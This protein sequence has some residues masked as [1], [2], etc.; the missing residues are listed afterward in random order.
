VTPETDLPFTQTPTPNISEQL[1]HATRSWRERLQPPAQ[2]ARPGSRRRTD[3][4]TQEQFASMIG[5]TVGWYRNL[6][7][8]E[9]AGYSDE[10]LEAVAAGYRLNSD[11]KR[12]LFLLSTGREPIAPHDASSVT[13][14]D[15]L[16]QFLDAQPWPA[17][18]YTDAWEIISTNE[19]MRTW[20]KWAV[21]GAN[22]MKWIFTSSDARTHLHRWSEDW[23]PLMISK[24]RLAL[25]RSP[26]NTAVA[27]LI[28]EIVRANRDAR[29]LWRV[30]ESQA[31]VDAPSRSL[32]LPYHGRIQPVS[33]LP[34]ELLDPPH[35]R[36]AAIIPRPPAA[37]DAVDC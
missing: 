31:T 21:P 7:L 14:I 15:A 37:R 32:N 34:F 6:E 5:Y 25:A 27:D 20:F 13:A 17:F 16:Q 8:G 19:D 22:V 2:T 23:A 24:M 33:V 10:F 26:E 9:Q 11:E 36:M 18:V 1:A 3:L 28:T 12:L 30:P 29:R 35:A 4:V